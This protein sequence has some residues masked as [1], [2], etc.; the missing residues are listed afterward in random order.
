MRAGP[1]V[2]T[3]T[4]PESTGKSTLAVALARQDGAELSREAARTY[5]DARAATRPPHTPPADLLGPDDVEPIARAQIASEDA[6]ATR[7][8]ASRAPVIVRDTDLVSTVVYARHYYGACPPWIVDAA[9]ARR[10]DVYLLCD[11]DLPWVPD[12]RRDQ[13]HARA[14]LRDEFARTLDAFGCA[15]T[16]VRGHGTAREGAARAAVDAARRAR[17]APS[18]DQR[19]AGTRP[20]LAPP[21]PPALPGLGAV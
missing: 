14:E 17:A 21:T 2:I 16:L 20:G 3:L 10:A 6:A 11:V 13:P 9:R 12:G 18:C 1:V 8:T 19:A 7:A 4:G 5:A 15:W